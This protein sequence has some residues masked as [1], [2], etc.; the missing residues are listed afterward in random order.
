MKKPVPDAIV[1]SITPHEP[2]PELMLAWQ[3]VDIESLIGI[4]K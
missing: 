1:A 2:K 4:D 3:C